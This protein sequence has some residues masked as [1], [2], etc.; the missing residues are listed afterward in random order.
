VIDAT[1]GLGRDAVLLA[2][3]GCRVTMIERHPVVAAL[4]ADGLARAAS[5]ALPWLR[6]L[7]GSMQLVTGDSARLVGEVADTGAAPPVIYLDPMFSDGRGSAAA[8]REMQYLQELHA[9]DSPDDVGDLFTAARA[10]GPERIVVKRPLHAVSLDE[11]PPTHSIE[12]ESVRFDVYLSRPPHR[13]AAYVR[14]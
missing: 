7:S 12:G 14:E 8:G 4:L 5:S 2:R 9:G 6:K 1:A 3:L 11:Q 13:R 10:V